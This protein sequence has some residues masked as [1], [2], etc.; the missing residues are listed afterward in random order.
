M[1]AVQRGQVFK[2]S[3][4]SWAYRYRDASG[5]RRQV[6]GFR[7]KSEAGAVLDEQLRRLRLGGLYR[8]DVTLAVLADRYLAQHQGDPA[9]IKKLRSDLRQATRVFEDVPIDRLVPADLAAWRAGLSEGARHGV[10]R[11]LK[12]VLRQAVAWRMLAENP[13]DGIK[14]PKPKRPEVRPFASW[15]EVEGVAAELGPRFRA[16]RS[17]PSNASTRRVSSSSAGSPVASGGASRSASASWTLL[18]RSRR[19]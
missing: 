3:G 9:T 5:R 6:G 14:N 7:S 4:G 1:P 18:T 8:E 19:G 13:A 15:E 11:S 12:Q 17:S 10:F 2:L 16:I